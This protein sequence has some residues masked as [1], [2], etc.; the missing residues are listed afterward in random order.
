MPLPPPLVEL[1]VYK[2]SG[3]LYDRG[4]KKGLGLVSGYIISDFAYILRVTLV[5]IYS[6]ISRCY[7]TAKLYKEGMCVLLYEWSICVFICWFRLQ[8]VLYI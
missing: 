5:Y 8:I 7:I 6:D 4:D 3:L 2:D 1:S